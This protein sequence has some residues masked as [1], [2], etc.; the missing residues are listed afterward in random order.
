MVRSR[1]P[2]RTRAALSLCLMRLVSRHTLS[3][4]TVGATRRV[5]LFYVLHQSCHNFGNPGPTREPL[6]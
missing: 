4:R 6:P 3:S 2:G 1:H 5:A